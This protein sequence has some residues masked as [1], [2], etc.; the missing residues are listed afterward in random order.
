[1][2]NIKEQ[3]LIALQ[4]I[5]KNCGLL[6]AKS[7]KQKVTSIGCLYKIVLVLPIFKN[8]YQKTSKKLNFVII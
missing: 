4:K 5:A 1:M 6:I 2:I 8:H 7:I 3:F